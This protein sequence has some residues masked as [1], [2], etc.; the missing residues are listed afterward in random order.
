MKAMMTVKDVKQYKA[1][2]KTVNNL[3]PR[4]KIL[5]ITVRKARPVAEKGRG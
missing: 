3:E 1:D 2:D 4:P 5:K